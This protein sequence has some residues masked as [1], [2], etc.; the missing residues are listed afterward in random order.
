MYEKQRVWEVWAVVLRHGGPELLCW[1][2]L[3]NCEI[4]LVCPVRILNLII[5]FH[6]SIWQ[7][8]IIH[9]SLWSLF[10]TRLDYSFQVLK[11]WT[12][13]NLSGELTAIYWTGAFFTRHCFNLLRVSRKEPKSPLFSSSIFKEYH[14]IFWFLQSTIL[15]P[16]SNE[17]L[18]HYSSRNGCH[19][20]SKKDR[21]QSSKSHQ[22]TLQRKSF[23][24]TGIP[25]RWPH[26][27]QET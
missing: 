12:S 27:R 15:W 4:N 5:L 20:V 18:Q 9:L 13:L 11:S 16:W 10:L 7:T 3:I 14:S 26:R 17:D 22:K 25:K 23:R 1:A 2:R 6:W 8:T 21:T 19:R 24:T